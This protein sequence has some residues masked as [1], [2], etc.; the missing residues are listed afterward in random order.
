MS[1]NH[2]QYN[3]S[4]HAVGAAAHFHRLDD[5]ENLDHVVPTLG[6]S[7]LPVTGGLSK[8]HASN[9]CYEVDEPRKRALLS[10]R[11]IDTLA[12]GRRREDRFETEVEA[13]IESLAVLGKLNVGL[14]RLHMLAIRDADE[15]KDDCEIKTKGSRIEGLE[16]GKVTAKVVLDDE[17]LLFCGS[18]EQLAGYYRQRSADWRNANARRF[19]TEASATELKE[20]RGCARFSLV[21][22]IEL[23]G[24]QDKEHPVT[25]AED[26]YTIIWKGFGRIILGEVF[27]K[28]C[29]RRITMMRLAMGSDAGGSASIGDGGT[30][31]QQ[32]GN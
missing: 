22:D 20:H 26:G 12:H 27:V 29:Y 28:G 31:G 2:R 6:A 18:Q 8:G 25:V 19:G 7:V 32:S 10:V 21:R 14:V 11:R 5:R 30:N 9:Y 23:S 15:D 13:E 1:E 17:P 24:T 3:F 4:G 16:L